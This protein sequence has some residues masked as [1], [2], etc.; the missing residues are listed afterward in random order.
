MSYL[1]TEERKKEFRENPEVYRQYR[2]EIEGELN[3]R[4]RFVS[5]LPSPTRI[6]LNRILF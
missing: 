5:L 2:K 3:T 4:F 1:V 6:S